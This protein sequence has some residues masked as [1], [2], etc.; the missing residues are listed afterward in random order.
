MTFFNIIEKKR[1]EKKRQHGYPFPKM[2]LLFSF[3]LMH[4]VLKMDVCAVVLLSL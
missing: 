1:K 3:V 4:F 2:V